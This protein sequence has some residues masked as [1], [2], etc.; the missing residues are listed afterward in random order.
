MYICPS[1]G[2]AYFC[3]FCGNSVENSL[4]LLLDSDFA[5]SVWRGIY[6]WLGLF[7]QFPQKFSTPFELCSCC[8]WAKTDETGFSNS[9]G[10]GYLGF[11]ASSEPNSVLKMGGRMW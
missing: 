6:D 7:Q 4:H 10:S 5:M 2:K 3:S 11:V 1:L 8:S 9:L